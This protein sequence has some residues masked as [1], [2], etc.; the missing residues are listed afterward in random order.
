MSGGGW[1]TVVIRCV[2]I[3]PAWVGQWRLNEGAVVSRFALSSN[4]RL[5]AT[6]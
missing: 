6:C 1:E 5:V 3:G 2:L 4:V